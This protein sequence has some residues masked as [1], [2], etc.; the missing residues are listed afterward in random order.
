MADPGELVEDDR[1]RL[2]LMCCHP[3]L[4][5][6]SASALALRLVVGVS[7]PT[8]PGSSWSPEPTMAARLTRGKKK[9][10]AAG[11]PFAVPDAAVLPDRLD[12]RR[13]DGLPRVHRRLR[14]RQRP[15]P[16]ARRAGR[17]G[18]PARAGRRS[19]AARRGRR[20]APCSRCCC[21]STRRRDARVD[22][23]G[24]LVL[25]ADQDRS[26]GSATRS[27]E[28]AALLD[29][30][31]ATRQ[32]ARG[33][34]PAPGPDRGR[35]RHGP[36]RGHHALGPHLRPLRP[37]S[38]RPTRRPAG[39]AVAVAERDGPHAGLA[40]LAGSSPRAATG[41]DAVRAELL[42]RAGDGGRPGRRTTRRS[43]DAATT[44][45][46]P[47]WS[48]GAASCPDPRPDPP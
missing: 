14:A 11:I 4:A 27:T 46:G 21:S 13:P 42:T 43:P 10:V 37:A 25:L 8:S 44:R 33:G 31:R 23:D 17:R 39:A 18:G 45:S 6:E 32:P 34:V 5:L 40:A 47:T 22:D 19:R 38:S 12:E 3:A 30:V 35:A 9:V 24:T 28:G 20:C 36:V 48:G 2:V 1:L 15:R 16:A 7:T 26:G 41:S 29:P